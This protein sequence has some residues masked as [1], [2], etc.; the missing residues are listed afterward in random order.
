[1]YRSFGSGLW[2]YSHPGRRGACTQW[3]FIPAHNH[4]EGRSLASLYLFDRL[5]NGRIIDVTLITHLLARYGSCF[6]RVTPV[7]KKT[8]QIHDKGMTN[9]LPE[10]NRKPL[11][12]SRQ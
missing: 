8:P 1:A 3:P 12:K 10:R 2:R 9:A 6:M 5:I 4:F 7:R 11:R